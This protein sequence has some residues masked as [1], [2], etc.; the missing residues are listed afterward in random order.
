MKSVGLQFP[1]SATFHLIRTE[2]DMPEADHPVEC[3][4]GDFRFGPLIGQSP[5]VETSTDKGLVSVHRRFY[6]AALLQARGPFSRTPAPP[7]FSGMNSIPAA[8]R[9]RH[10]T[11]KV[12]RRG[13]APPPSNCRTVTTPT[14][15]AVASCCWDQSRSARAARHWAG[16]TMSAA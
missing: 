8:S 5:G 9:A 3:V 16:V 7:P 13:C 2:I 14:R 11:S 12:A 1:R 4:A 10:T 15:A 6:Q